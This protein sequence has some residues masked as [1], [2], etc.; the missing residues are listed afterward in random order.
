MRHGKCNLSFDSQ[1]IHTFD[2]QLAGDNSFSLVVLGSASVH[3][4]IKAGGFTDLKGANA[5]VGQLAKLGVVTN[6]HLILQPL[7]LRLGGG[8][9]TIHFYMLNTVD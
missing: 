5:L 6:D 8:K 3:A 4:T 9:N 1:L 7:D 2:L